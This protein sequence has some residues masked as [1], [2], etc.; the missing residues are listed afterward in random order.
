MRETRSTHEIIWDPIDERR[1]LEGCRLESIEWTDN[2][3]LNAWPHPI[4]LVGWIEPRFADWRWRFYN[5]GHPRCSRYRRKGGK[6]GLVPRGR[7]L[8]RRRSYSTFRLL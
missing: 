7:T 4:A 3:S 6:M 8:A 5:L 1:R 2:S